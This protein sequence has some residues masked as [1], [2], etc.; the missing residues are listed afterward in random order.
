MTLFIELYI[1]HTCAYIYN[2][3]I[4]FYSVS[5]SLH[6]FIFKCLRWLSGILFDES[7]LIMNEMLDDC[8]IFDDMM[9]LILK[10]IFYDI[11]ILFTANKQ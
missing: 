1:N 5:I 9:D 2:L 4:Y 6:Q 10:I 11:I 3:F 7:A 8:G